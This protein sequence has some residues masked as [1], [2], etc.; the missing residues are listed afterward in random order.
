[1]ASTAVT[2]RDA[3]VTALAASHTHYDLSAT[4]RVMVGRYSAPPGSSAFVA[5]AN[6]TIEGQADG[7]TLRDHAYVYTID[8]RGWAPVTADTPATRGAAALNLASDIVKAIKDARYNTGG[9]LKAINA[10]RGI[11]R[12]DVTELDGEEWDLPPGWA[13]CFVVVRLDVHLD[14]GL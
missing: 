5:V 10:V 13:S 2:I 1:M 3:I 6:P 12:F 14:R 7:L 8:I 4:D 9:G 11:P